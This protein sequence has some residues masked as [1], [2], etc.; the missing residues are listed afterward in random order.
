MIIDTLIELFERDLGL[1]QK[2]I[3]LYRDQTAIWRAEKAI[4]NSAGNLALHLVG[5]LNA[6][7]GNVLGGG[8]YVR[9]RDLEFSTKDVPS[10]QLL[11]MLDQTKIIVRNALKQTDEAMLTKPFPIKIWAEEKATGHTLMLLAAH[12]NYHLGQINYHR[13]LL[14]ETAEP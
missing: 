7:I 1:V 6:F 5:N 9:Q 11:V 13:R 12:L 3:G 2:E 14:D 8:T 10:T 4:A